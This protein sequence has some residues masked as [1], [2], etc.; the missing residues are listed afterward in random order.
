MSTLVSC[1]FISVPILQ[2]LKMC[3]TW[4]LT[5]VLLMVTNKSPK[6]FVRLKFGGGRGGGG[7]DTLND[8]SDN[9]FWNSFSTFTVSGN[10]LKRCCFCCVTET[11]TGAFRP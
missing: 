11:G 10:L 7:G 1:L 4:C 9:V 3:H 6:G 5:I 2:K 8:S